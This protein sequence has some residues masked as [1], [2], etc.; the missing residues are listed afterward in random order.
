MNKLFFQKIPTEP[1]VRLARDTNK[2][3]SYPMKQGEVGL[4]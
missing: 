2:H 4:F 1:E 3:K